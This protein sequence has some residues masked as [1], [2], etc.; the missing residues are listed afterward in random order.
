MEDD[1]Y[2]NVAR[3]EGRTRVQVTLRV[4]KR[5]KRDSPVFKYNNPVI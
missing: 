4:A 2:V 1:G 3:N 5:K